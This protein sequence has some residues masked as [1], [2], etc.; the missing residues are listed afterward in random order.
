MEEKIA[1][2]LH[3][4]CKRNTK[5]SGITCGKSVCVRVECSIAEENE[6]TLGWEANKSIG[7][8]LPCAGAAEFFPSDDIEPAALGNESLY[9]ER[10]D[11]R[12]DNRSEPACEQSYET[13]SGEDERFQSTEEGVKKATLSSAVFLRKFSVAKKLW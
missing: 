8:C 12:S 13:D 3:T 10:S 6:D 1:F 9:E 11:N 4:V 7:Y 5:Y 2:R